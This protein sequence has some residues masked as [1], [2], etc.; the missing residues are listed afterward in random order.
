MTS[1]ISSISLHHCLWKQ[2]DCDKIDCDSSGRSSDLEPLVIVV[3]AFAV[4]WNGRKVSVASF[5]LD[6]S[7][8]SSSIVVDKLPLNTVAVWENFFILSIIWWLWLDLVGKLFFKINNSKTRAWRQ[9]KY[10]SQIWRN[11]AKKMSFR[12]CIVFLRIRN[13]SHDTWFN[14]WESMERSRKLNSTNLGS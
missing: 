6:C 11:M 7:S 14:L 5:L 13:R 12:I 1:P 4:E 2:V 3:V 8:N 10:V 9:V